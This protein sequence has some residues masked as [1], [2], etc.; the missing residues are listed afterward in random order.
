MIIRSSIEVLCALARMCC[1]VLLTFIWSTSRKADV[2]AAVA[3]VEKWPYTCS[4]H[5]KHVRAITQPDAYI[6]T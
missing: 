2:R 1:T 6:S 5:L 3:S 4:P